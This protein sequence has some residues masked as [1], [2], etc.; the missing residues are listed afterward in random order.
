MIRCRNTFLFTALL[1]ASLLLGSTSALAVPE[2]NSIEL[3]NCTLAMPG[4]T[5]TAAA[6]CGF[7][8]VPEN[9][10]EP[11]GRKIRLHVAVGDAG[12]QSPQPD[13]LFFFAGGPGQAATETWP[14]IRTMLGKIRRDRD[15]IM[16]DQRG[17]GQSNRLQCT[18]EQMMDLNAEIDF[19]EVARET[20]KCL[21]QL[22]GDPRF[23]TTTIAMQ[24]ID[25][26]RRA[27]GYEQINIMG[28]SY[29]TRAAQVYL[30]QFP[31]TVRTMT[32]DS[33]VPMQLALGQEHA[34]MLDRAVDLVMADC[35]ADADCAELFPD[36][37]EELRTLLQGLRDE[38]RRITITHP[39][40][41]Q[42]QELRVSA[43][44]MAVA[45]RF[46]SYASETQ[47]LLPLLVH[48][49]VSTGNLERMASQ[50]MMVMAN[51][52][53]ML[54]RGMELAVMCSEDYPFLNLYA[55]YSDTIIGNIMLE[56]IRA[57]C[58]VWPR[59][60]VPDDFHSAFDS[61]VPVLLLSGERDPVTPPH[62][63]AQAAEAYPN[64][65]NLV[66]PGQSHS[67]SSL[68]CLQEITAAFV[69]AGTVDELDTSCV[70]SIG[71]SPFFSSLL[72]PSP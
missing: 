48:E 52:N 11:D 40:T 47:A 45:L 33:V 32:L 1:G 41:G 6:R 50:A 35:A 15:I 44:T 60:E 64:H 19:A 22:D 70:S 4:S 43:E 27:M 3:S 21:A 5:A 24:D 46:L 30:R 25:Q 59:G 72:G 42:P 28:I 49:A 67:V 61:D 71:P 56:G 31:D 18:S 65:V 8:E 37:G 16:V 7:L 57:Q 14:M 54:S 66:A 63:A 17:T 13:P 29:G 58:E 55:D 23:Y 26:V 51:L 38:P 53:D 39:V 68:A 62:Y 2:G 10:A 34:P 20:E 36:R 9:P 69:Q 12:A